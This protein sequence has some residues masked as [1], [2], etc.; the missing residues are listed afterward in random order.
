MF[1]TPQTFEPEMLIGK[2]PDNK[3]TPDGTKYNEMEFNYMYPD[4]NFKGEPDPND[5]FHG[6]IAGV[7]CVKLVNMESSYGLTFSTK[8]NMFGK[9]SLPV[10]IDWN[11]PNHVAIF[12]D[13]D[14]VEGMED[15]FFK[16]LRV[17][18][19][20]LL[21]DNGGSLYPKLGKEKMKE[22]DLCMDRAKFA[23]HIKVPPTQEEID[24]DIT[25]K[26][27][28]ASNVFSKWYK[29]K[30]FQSKPKIKENA[31]SPEELSKFEKMNEQKSE[32]LTKGEKPIGCFS[33]TKFYV[34]A[35][36]KNGDVVIKQHDKFTDFNNKSIKYDMFLRFPNLYIG[37]CCSIVERCTEIFVKEMEETESHSKYTDNDAA[38]ES[39]KLTDGQSL[40]NFAMALGETLEERPRNGESAPKC[41]DFDGDEGFQFNTNV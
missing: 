31:M 8:A 23:S 36:N 18:A 1:F 19:I 29:L 13:K 15:G 34:P 41:A 7:P 27:A 6:R 40:R 37:Q 5:R 33:G 20:S 3:E 9:M 26:K 21:K 17:R 38:I 32:G 39:L 30:Y 12:G 16:K 28:K 4:K 14:Y 35:H 10:T 24:E 2:K 11:N 25:G 22:E